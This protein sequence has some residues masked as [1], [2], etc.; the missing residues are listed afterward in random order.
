MY[1]QTKTQA[2]F[3]L[4]SQDDTLIHG[5]LKALHVSPYKENYEDLYQ[6][7]LIAFVEAYQNFPGNPQTDHQS[8]MVYCFQAVKW[9]LLMY[10]RYEHQQNAKI[11]F[12]NRTDDNHDALLDYLDQISDSTCN[13]EAD[14]VYQ[15]CFE[16]LYQIC[17]PREQRFLVLRYF[18]NLD[19]KK[20]A[21]DLKVSRRTANNIKF[22][23]Q[24]KFSR[25][26]TE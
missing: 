25:I 18:Y 24:K 10:F 13:L 7:G 15:D 22:R 11:G 4:I 19:L 3:T 14:Q 23:V 6:E 26:I 8:L 12:V 1:Q 21:A 2:A 9:A 17:T 16:Q 5:V 20:I